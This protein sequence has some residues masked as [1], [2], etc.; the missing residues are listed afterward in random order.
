[1]LNLLRSEDHNNTSALPN[2]QKIHLGMMILRSPNPL[3]APRTLEL[4]QGAVK[5]LSEHFATAI[6]AKLDGEALAGYVARYKITGRGEPNRQ[7]R[8]RRPAPRAN[9]AK[10]SQG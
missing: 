6:L 1:M 5:H 9:Q 3:V 4:E 2:S 8:G 10:L 7:H